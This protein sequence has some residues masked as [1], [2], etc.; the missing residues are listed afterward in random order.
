MQVKNIPQGKEKET[1]RD[2]IPQLSAALNHAVV[3]W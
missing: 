3:M 2:V 1:T